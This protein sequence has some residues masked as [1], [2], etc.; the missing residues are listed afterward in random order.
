[1]A[2]R[3]RTPSDLGRLVAGARQRRGLT[4]VELAKRTGIERTYLARIEAGMTVILL[5]RVLKL[6]NALEVDLIA[7]E[8]RGG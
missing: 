3:L 4:Q 1:M 6:L 5:E 7:V 8:R 2:W